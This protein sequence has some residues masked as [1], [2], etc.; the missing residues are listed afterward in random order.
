MKRISVVILLTIAMLV[1]AIT[2]A[3][4]DSANSPKGHD[5]LAPHG[6]AH[7]LGECQNPPCGSTS[8]ASQ[9]NQGNQD[10]DVHGNSACT[11][12]ACPGNSG[13]AHANHG[14]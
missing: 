10:G 13:E 1:A 9:G 2:P 14:K 8:D 6:F 3:A 7:G 12:E 11:G 4:A 5:G